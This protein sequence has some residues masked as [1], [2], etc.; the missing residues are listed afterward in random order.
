MSSPT[1]KIEYSSPSDNNSL[2]GESAYCFFQVKLEHAA[3]RITK[4]R[5]KGKYNHFFH[6]TAPSVFEI[7]FKRKMIQHLYLP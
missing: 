6:N 7:Y 4:D 3:H 1:A 5:I 2:G